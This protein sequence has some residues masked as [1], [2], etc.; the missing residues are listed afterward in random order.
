[1][2]VSRTKALSLAIITVLGTTSV[3]AL[4]AELRTVEAPIEGK[5]IVVL[6]KDVAALS[7]ETMRLASTPSVA[8]VARTVS[9]VSGAKLGKSFQN[10]LR[11]FAVEA[12]DAALARL[13]ND[14]RVD[15][16]QEDGIKYVSAT[17][18]NPTW[19]IDR[20][21]QRDLPLSKSYSYDT[22]GSGVHAYIIDSGLN[23]SHNE[24][25]G[26]VGNGFSSVDG[27][28]PTSDCHGHGT[29]VAGTVA[30]T[31]WGVAKRA[32]VHPVRVFGCSGSSSDSTVIAAVDW[33]TANHIKP[34]VANMSLGGP[35]SPALDTAVN[36]LIAAGVVTAVAAGNDNL[37]ACTESPSRVPAALTV[38][39]TGQNDAR[40]NWGGG[41]ASSW[42]SCLDLFA[43][44]TDIVSAG[45]T[46]T[47]GSRLMSGTSMASPHVAGA[48][49]LYLTNHPSASVQEV[50][51]AII[52]NATTGK[53]TDLRGSPNR[54]L[55]TVFSGG[56]PP[57]NT[58][59]VAD[60]SSSV[61]GLTVQFTDASSDADGSIAS[62]SWDFGDG[63]SSTSTSPSKTYSAAGAYAVTLTVTDDKGASTRKSA[64]VIVSSGG[65]GGDG[66]LQNG[67]PV[68]GVS[69]ARS[70]TQYWQISVPASAGQ[71]RVSIAG[72]NGDADL[73]VRRG[74]RPTTTL[75]NCR[76]WRTGNNESCSLGN[77][78]ATTYHIMV[79]GYS[80]YSGVTL[81]ASY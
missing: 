17:Q 52:D 18:S 67:V 53:V 51:K 22:D 35:S 57:A 10:A 62:R 38:G 39:A 80:A 19:G 3:Q 61:N 24:F 9:A 42:G 2:K 12:D 49:V 31:T 64:N 76:P 78:G 73:Y 54:L 37:D 4:A 48:A 71:L 29:H 75:Y 66:G 43:P 11:G 79:H 13:L 59:P 81:T 5:Y 60:F 23:A 58:P 55:Y 70:S 41:Q 47:T 34:A 25:S 74:A 69:G 28:A 44:G 45:S 6:K 26:R 16:I 36:N 8:Q 63:T 40:S 68:S 32:T 27:E 21:D 56:N 77:N 46:N 7:S 72:G 20:I 1:M 50:S 15:Y 33:V 30:G 14:P 65:G